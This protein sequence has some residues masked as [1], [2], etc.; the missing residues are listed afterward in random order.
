[1]SPA[2]LDQFVRTSIEEVR[3]SNTR[4]TALNDAS[5]NVFPIGETI[6][7]EVFSVQEQDV[8]GVVVKERALSVVERLKVLETGSPI[9][10]EA[11]NLPIQNKRVER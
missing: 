7:S 5:Q 6:P 3:E 11:D 10:L 4:F 9:W 2:K 1:M 8:E